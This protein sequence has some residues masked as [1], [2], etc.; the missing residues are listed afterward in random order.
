MRSEGSD[1]CGRLHG[2]LLAIEREPAVDGGERAIV[3]PPGVSNAQV[4]SNWAAVSA[5]ILISLDGVQ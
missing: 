2:E 4:E 5:E 3:Y 1:I